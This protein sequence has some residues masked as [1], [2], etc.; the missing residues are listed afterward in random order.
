ML[1]AIEHMCSLFLSKADMYA[2]SCMFTKLSLVG[3]LYVSKSITAKELECSEGWFPTEAD[4]VWGCFGFEGVGEGAVFD[5]G[6]MMDCL[7]PKGSRKGFMLEGFL[8]VG[9]HRSSE[10]I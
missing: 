5:P 10:I 1:M 9:D 7:G 3:S 2:V 6:S 4:L 8:C